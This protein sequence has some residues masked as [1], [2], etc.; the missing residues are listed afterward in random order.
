MAA[1][2]LALVAV[3]FAQ[4]SPQAATAAGPAARVDPRSG[5]FTIGLGEW[6]IAPEADAVRPGPVTFVVRNSGKEVHGFRIKEER[7]G[8]NGGDRFEARTISLAPGA[9]ARLSLD[10]PEGVYSLECFVEG[11][12]DLGMERV[13]RVSADAPLVA[14][15][16][17][18]GTLVEISGF[19]F[20]PGTIRAKVGTTVKWTNRDPAPHTASA[21]NGAWTSKTLARGASYSRRFTKTGSYAFFCAIHPQMRGKLVVSR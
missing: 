20:K 12:D 18:R 15:T 11:H 2:A 3:A 9:T 14:P 6:G 17:R 1:L 7:D 21:V 19:V 8:G 10:L 13:F 16:P 4:P 5:G